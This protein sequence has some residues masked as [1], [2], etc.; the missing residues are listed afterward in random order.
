MDHSADGLIGCNHDAPQQKRKLVGLDHLF[1]DAATG[2]LGRCQ[3]GGE[4][5]R[6]K[7]T[8]IRFGDT[9]EKSE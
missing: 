3:R 1:G 9:K 8:G 2:R 4:V 5:V 6:V 7:A